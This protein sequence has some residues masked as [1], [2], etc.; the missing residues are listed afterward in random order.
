[1]FTIVVKDVSCP[2]CGAVEMNEDGKTVNIRG[3]KVEMNGKWWSQCLICA[4]AGDPQK[5]WF[6]E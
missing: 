4:E 3:F 6:C 2:K 1:M 5:G